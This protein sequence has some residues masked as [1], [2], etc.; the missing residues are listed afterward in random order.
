MTRACVHL[1]SVPNLDV[2]VNIVPVDFVS[3]AIVHL[4]RDPENFGRVY[5]LDN[6]EPVHFS[7]LA[8]WLAAQGLHP[9][10]ISFDDWRAELFK[11]L[12]H[13]PSGGWEPYLPLIEE[14]EEKQVF[15]PEF[16][17]SNTLT[18]LDGSGIHCHPV[19]DRLFSAYLKYFLPRGFLEKPAAKPI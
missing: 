3:A 9:R 10:T 16:D 7:R 5:H 15:M 11:Q 1:G 19:N 6:P 8:D 4:S 12:P 13:M 17:L 14:V 18:G 2:T